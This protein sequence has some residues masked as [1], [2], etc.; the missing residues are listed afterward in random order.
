METASLFISSSICIL[1][2]VTLSPEGTGYVES[3][4]SVVIIVLLVGFVGY[5]IFQLVIAY[6]IG[7]QVW[8]YEQEEYE[9]HTGGIASLARVTVGIISSRSRSQITY[10]G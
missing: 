3:I 6:K 7:F 4:A 1:E 10:A 5:M 2:G 9:N 8:L